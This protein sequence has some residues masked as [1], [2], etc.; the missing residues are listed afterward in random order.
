MDITGKNVGHVLIDGIRCT[1]HNS[2]RSSAT[3]D[4][5]GT[6]HYHNTYVG[7]GDSIISNIK[8]GDEDIA[9]APFLNINSDQLDNSDAYYSATFNLLDFYNH[10]EQGTLSSYSTFFNRLGIDKE[11]STF[12]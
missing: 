6:I 7:Y 11:R 10:Y 9:I 1:K 4:S 5:A 2:F 8:S 3:S 12:T